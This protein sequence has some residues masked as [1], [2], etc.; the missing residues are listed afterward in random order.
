VVSSSTTSAW[1]NAE[2]ATDA[3][4]NFVVDWSGPPPGTSGEPH[5][6]ARL[7]D[8]SGEAQGPVFVVS[9]YESRKAAVA[10]DAE[11]RFLIAWVQ[12]HYDERRGVF[13]RVFD[14][15]GNPVGGE[16]QVNASTGMRFY[17]VSAAMDTD[18]SFVLVWDEGQDPHHVDVFARRFDTGGTPAS[19]PLPVNRRAAYAWSR[20]PVVAGDREGNFVVA[21][22]RY[23]AGGFGGYDVFAQRFGPD[24]LFADGFESGGLS[25]WS[26]SA[27]GGDLS[28]APEA[29]MRSSTAGLQGQVNDTQGLWVQDDS[30]RGEHRYRA[31]FYFDPGDFDPG[32]A[33]GRFR[34]RI[35]IGFDENP[36]RRLF[37]LVLRRRDGEFALMARARRDDGAR[38]DTGFT[39]IG[40]G[41]HAVEVA[42]ARSS[43]VDAADGTLELWMDGSLAG[44][45]AGID[46]DD[47]ALDF[48][49]MG[50]L[51]VKSGASGTMYWDEFASRRA[52]PIGP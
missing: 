21:W 28:V 7:F 40:P 36:I 22:N 27:G 34:A 17:S 31:R 2:V 3:A 41:A 9:A 42:W 33:Q 35:F 32:E 44:S 15:D 26:A 20:S 29:A 25:A 11:G 47:G 10:R 16:F 38:S 51:S 12:G 4:G 14:A 49:R 50:V 43:G 19:G 52:T 24:Q 39:T 48:V 45:V 37:T 1:A 13:A 23:F 6:V 46:N 8:A 18:D 5:A 30:P